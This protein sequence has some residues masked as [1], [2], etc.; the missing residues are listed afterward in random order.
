LGKSVNVKDVSQMNALTGSKV[1]NSTA[2]NSINS[3]SNAGNEKVVRK[4]GQAD[5]GGKKS[6]FSLKRDVLPK[7]IAQMDT[8]AGKEMFADASQ[9]DASSK[10]NE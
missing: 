4:P 3:G 7:D 9:K 10:P 8:I 2:E 6:A 1:T 5:L